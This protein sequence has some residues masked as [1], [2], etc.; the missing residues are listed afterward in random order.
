MELSLKFVKFPKKMN[1]FLEH[2]NV[3]AS[4]ILREKFSKNFFQINQSLCFKH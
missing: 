2:L 4:G 1:F 3:T